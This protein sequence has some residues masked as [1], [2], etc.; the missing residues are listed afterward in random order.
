MMNQMNYRYFL[1]SGWRGRPETTT[2]IGTKFIETLHAL[3]AI[4]PIFTSWE[5]VNIRNM[6]SFSLAA[7]PSRVAATIEDNV[8][9]ND[10]GEP[11]PDDGYHA[12]ATVGVFKDPRSVTF[13]ADAGGKYGGG[14]NLEFGDY[15]VAA[16]LSIVTYPLYRAALLA[17]NAIWQAP[18]ACAQASRTDSV[19]T[20]IQLGD[21]KAT[22]IDS[23][24][25]VPSDPAFPYSVF[26]IPW[27]A[28]LSAEL[29]AG[30]R[31]TPEILTERTADGGLLMSV[32]T[33]RFDPASREHLRG[34]R[35]LVEALIAATG[36]R[37]GYKES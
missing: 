3:S 2:A 27:I 28:Y 32:T 25:A 29:G 21:L 10:Y 18:W 13:K 35:I 14:T 11:R 24:P 16:D 17:I 15:G 30:L 5:I 12:V 37:Y 4:D 9:R 26:H 19:E 31:L 22:R 34:A 1:R 33:E 8:V 36:G 7:A 23:A 6:S 20:P